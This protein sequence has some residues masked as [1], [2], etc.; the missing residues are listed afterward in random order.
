[1]V[2]IEKPEDKIG[3]RAV[4]QVDLICLDKPLLFRMLAVC[5]SLLCIIIFSSFIFIFC[6]VRGVGFLRYF[7]AKQLPNF[8]L[9][10]PILSLAVCS[11]VHYVSILYRKFPL[12]SMHKEIIYAAEMKS[13]GTNEGSD[14]MWISNS[15][16]SS[17][18]TRGITLSAFYR[19]P[20]VLLQR[21]YLRSAYAS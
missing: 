15:K 14:D 5:F 6:F 3:T 8:L 17:K 12:S 20:V 13:M 18:S 9:A 10:S 16:L 4:I 21:S 7:Q 19:C 1:M 11:I 2:R